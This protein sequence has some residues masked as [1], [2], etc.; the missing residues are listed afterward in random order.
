MLLL[1]HKLDQITERH[2]KDSAELLF[3][4]FFSLIESTK[5]PTDF[6]VEPSE[7]YAATE[8]LLSAALSQKI[9]LISK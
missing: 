1:R 5:S 6:P 9:E 3:L 2:D 7:L 4:P 8:T